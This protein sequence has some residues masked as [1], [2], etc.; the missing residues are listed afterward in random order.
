MGSQRA[1]LRWAQPAGNLEAWIFSGGCRPPLPS[2]V[3]ASPSAPRV[4]A[5]ALS[6]LDHTSALHLQQTLP[7]V[8]Q[9]GLAE[10]SYCPVT[11]LAAQDK[12]TSGQ[13][14]P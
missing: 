1:G 11:S 3:A 14:T 13:L 5:P 2:P 9:G 6:G 7:E 4:G 8:L 10:A 12:S